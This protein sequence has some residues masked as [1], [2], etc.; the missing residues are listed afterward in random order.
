MGMTDDRYVAALEISSSKIIAVVGRMRPGGQLDILASEQE[1]EVESV[2]YGVIRNLEEA[3]TRIAR[4]ISKLE[5]KPMVAPRKITSIF[6]GLSGLSLKSI[7]SKT[8]LTL[9]DDTEITE[10][11][12]K[13]LLT[14]ARSTA[15]D[16]SLE[17]IDAV[18]RFYVVGKQKTMSPVG[19]VGN[20]IST[21]FDLIVCHPEI[22]NN[23]IR[24]VRDKRGIPIKGVV[25]TALAVGQIVLSAE[26]K[27]YGC[28]LVDM[29]AET[30]TVSI[31][32]SGHLHYF[33]TLPLG[34]RN[35]TRDLSTANLLEERAE[36]IKIKAGSAILRDSSASLVSSGVDAHLVSNIIIARS[37]EIV[38]NI[39]KQFDY[40]ELD[41]AK[42]IPGGIVLIGGASKL[43]GMIELLTEK[44]GL[45]VTRGVLPSYIHLEDVKISG[46]EIIEV[47][48]ILYAG[49]SGNDATCLEIPQELPKMGNPNIEEEEE[50]VLSKPKPDNKPKGPSWWGRLKDKAIEAFGSNGEDDSDALD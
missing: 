50:E 49:A 42:D 45:N 11:V 32:R 37:E 41:P 19:T 31:Y 47:A 46:P 38:T 30:T 6:V 17:V 25:V 29:G 48:S 2:R 35:I 34:G 24:T 44:S 20:S 33:A 40:A 39:I 10:E 5:R 22:K 27:R 12:I 26:Q 9:P 16:S 43:N 1:K 36:D 23:L 4:I 18:P 15:I 13:R 7:P 8:L 3:A 21:D 14:Q 28:M